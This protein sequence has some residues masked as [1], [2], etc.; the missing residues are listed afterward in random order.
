[1][2]STRRYAKSRRRAKS[3]YRYKKKQKKS[4]VQFSGQVNKLAL[5]DKLYAKLRYADTLTINPLAAQ[6][7][8]YLFDANSLYDPN[9]EVLGH[10]VRFFDQLM[11]LYDH[12]VVTHSNI[13]VNF[14]NL[15]AVPMIVGIHC[16]DNNIDL[17]LPDYMEAR[18]TVLKMV[19]PLG[20]GNSTTQLKMSVNIGKF[21]GRKSVLSDPQLKGSSVTSPT[22][23]AF[24]HVIC[25][26]PDGSDP[27]GVTATAQI[28]Y[29]AW[30]IEPTLPPIS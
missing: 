23:S 27:A 7:G 1:M 5:G 19:A 12:Y 20:G 17:S 21:L 3:R 10:K 28:D 2:P 14:A 29:S 25:F 9:E 18:N 26:A 8:V 24:F 4:A 22:E 11:P 6:A 16:S 15:S 13:T 30:F